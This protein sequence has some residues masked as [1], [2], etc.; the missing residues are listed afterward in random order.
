[1]FSAE[2]TACLV[3]NTSIWSHWGHRGLWCL[4]SRADQALVE[5]SALQV[6]AAASPLVLNLDNELL[7]RLT[8]GA[9]CKMPHMS[10]PC[11]FLLPFISASCLERRGFELLVAGT[12][13]RF[14]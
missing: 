1:M 8:L 10:L 13:L 14:R 12:F 3:T 9:C 6:Q 11:F 4:P 7:P 5:T 2:G